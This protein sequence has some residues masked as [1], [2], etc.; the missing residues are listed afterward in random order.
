VLSDALLI[1]GLVLI[2]L[3]FGLAT[4]LREIGRVLDRLVNV[5]LV[6]ILV[7]YAAQLAYLLFFAHR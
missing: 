5:L 2:G 3:K 6:L 1:T 7:A 4:R